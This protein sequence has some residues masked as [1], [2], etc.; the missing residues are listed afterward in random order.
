MSDATD[1]EPHGHAHGAPGGPGGPGG[2]DGPPKPAEEFWEELYNDPARVGDGTRVWSGS[3]NEL[4]VR[5][6]ADL[7][8]GRALDVGCG[9]GGDAVW[10]AR[11]GWHVTGVDVSPTALRRATEGA[12]QERVTGRVFFQQIDLSVDFPDGRFDLVAA[13]YFHSF[14]ADADQRTAT[15]RR[16]AGTVAP[17]GLLLVIG[18]AGWPA[19]V[20]EDHPAVHFPTTAE[21]LADL[22]LDP[23][24][25]TVELEDLV[26]REATGPDGQPGTRA[27]NVL[28]VRRA[29]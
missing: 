6:V 13:S 16:A 29:G 22:A 1:H 9:E 11:Q 8:P 28:R 17:G 24:E 20:G 14:A 2:H 7:P 19:W 10:L 25:W 4:L 27:D 12:E 23:Q 3:P 18:H 5:E 21:V 26:E 15:L